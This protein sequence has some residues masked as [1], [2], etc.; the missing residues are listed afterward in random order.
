MIFPNLVNWFVKQRSGYTALDVGEEFDI[1]SQWQQRAWIHESSVGLSCDIFSCP[2]G[3][4]PKELTFPSELASLVI[5]DSQMTT[6]PDSI[7]K[8]KNLTILWITRSNISKLPENID[9]LSNL[10]NLCIKRGALT[11]LP[12]SIS[13]LTHLHGLDVQMNNITSL[14]ANFDKL[15]SLVNLDISFNPIDDVSVIDQMPMIN[16]WS[17]QQ[18]QMYRHT[19]KPN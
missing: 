17:R 19:L 2:G 11:E 12:E 6:F 7:L 3:E 14:P 13:N 5:E 18:A 1:V 15:Q 16:Y 9:R 8:L 4:M 10:T